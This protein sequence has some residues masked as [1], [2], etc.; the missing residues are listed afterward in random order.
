MLNKDISKV[1]F[2]R[3]S[4]TEQCGVCFGWHLELWYCWPQINCLQTC[5][6]LLL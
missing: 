5:S 2:V 3:N 4:R 1:I 6:L